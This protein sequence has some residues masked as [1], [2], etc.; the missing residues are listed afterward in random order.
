MKKDKIFILLGLFGTSVYAAEPITS[1]TDAVIRQQQRDEA[2][3]KQ[4]QPTAT[5]QTGLEKAITK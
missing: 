2:L 3:Q 1:S 4:I 5:V